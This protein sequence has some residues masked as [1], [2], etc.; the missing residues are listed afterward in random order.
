MS[1]TETDLKMTAHKKTAAAAPEPAELIVPRLLNMRQAAKYLGCSFWTIRDYVL[2][3]LI[4]V[5]QLPPL[6]ARSGARQRETLRRV[7]ID[8]ADLDNF[9]ETRKIRA[10]VPRA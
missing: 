5:V 1:V 10:E 3:G 7:V 8:R 4:P 9:V 2:Q 6:R